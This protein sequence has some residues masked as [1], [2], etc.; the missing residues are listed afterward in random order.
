V[1]ENCLWSSN[2]RRRKPVDRT[3]GLGAELEKHALSPNPLPSPPPKNITFPT[4]GSYGDFPSI[5]LNVQP[6]YT[7]QWNVSYQR[8]LPGTWLATISYLGNKTAHIWI[9][10]Q[11]NPAVFIPGNCGASPCSTTN[12]TNQRRV[13]YLENPAQ[14][15]Y[16]GGV[17]IQDMGTN[18]NYNGMLVSIQH[19]FADNF[20]LLSNYTW[21]HCIDEADY[22]GPGSSQAFQSPY[23]RRGDRGSCGF[24]H[25]HVSNTSLVAV[26]PIRGSGWRGRAFG[27]WE[28]AP[29]ISV[30]SGD[31]LN[32][33]TGTDNSL[34]GQGQDRPNVVLPSSY[35]LRKSVA[36][37][38]NPAAFVPNA[39]GTFGTLEGML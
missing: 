4:G 29:I 31:R 20:T 5:D 18:A 23:N 33:L 37:W 15:V 16:F 28:F 13:L 11:I 2:H 1:R 7:V 36:L 26:S 8:E 12:N 6:T 21:S 39:L 10:A 17:G 22:L 38:L 27:S 25:H 3:H 19:R 14:G 35:A 30:R 9:P 34:T 32:V 24:D